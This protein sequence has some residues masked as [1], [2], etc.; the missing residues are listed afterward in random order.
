MIRTI[1]VGNPRPWTGT[2]R[3]ESSPDPT[4]LPVFHETDRWREE[5]VQPDTFNIIFVV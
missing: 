2:Y 3:F 4:R 1:P 5:N